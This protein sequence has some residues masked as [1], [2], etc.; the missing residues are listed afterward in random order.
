MKNLLETAESPWASAALT[1][2][3]P[4]ATPAALATSDLA[5]REALAELKRLQ[6]AHPFWTN[7]LFRACAAGLLSRE[8]FQFIFSQYYLYSRNFT[9]YLAGV[10][11]NC[12]DDYYRSRLSENV[13]E[14]GGSRDV[15]E[16]HAEIFRGFLRDGLG[17]ELATIEYREFT[18]YFAKE[19]LDCCLRSTATRGSAFLSLGTEGIVARM[20]GVLVEGMRQAG[21]PDQELRFFHIHIKC[22][23][24]HAAT[25]EEMMAS[26]ANEPAWYTTCLD[27]MNHA[28]DLRSRFFENLYEALRVRRVQRTLDNIQA[29]K[30]LIPPAAPQDKLVLPYGTKGESLYANVHE[31]L[32]IEFT[33]ERVPFAHEVIDTRIVRISSGKYNEHH[34]HAH[35]S[36]FYVM[37]GI[38]QVVIDGSIVPAR[39]GDIVFVPRWAM[40]QTQ[41]LGAGE[42]VILAVTDHGLTGKAYLGDYL[43]TARM[44]RTAADAEVGS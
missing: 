44:K 32:N 8:D 11:S 24:E 9:R 37:Q 31:K 17:I 22:D 27:A 28:L 43:R 15:E 40:H 23:D 30:S 13:W 16:R 3:P 12:E 19:Y 42:M 6:A 39:A 38:G 26:Y 18:R 35:E 1:S 20:Y 10:M 29:R 7:S 5:T 4:P 14:E 25:L 21:I 33:V 2:M 36:V 41:N 34:K